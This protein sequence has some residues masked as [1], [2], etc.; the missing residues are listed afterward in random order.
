[1]DY[2]F[3]Q[4]INKEKR[5]IGLTLDIFIPAVI[6]AVVFFLALRRPLICV[7]CCVLWSGII[8]SLKK[9]K[10][11]SH[12]LILAYWY[13]P[14]IRLKDRGGQINTKSIFGE[15]PPAEKVYWLG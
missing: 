13:L 14:G 5:I 11:P 4:Y 9:G 3:F 6:F 10:P 12:L 2:F 8:T 15:I 1:M 7:V